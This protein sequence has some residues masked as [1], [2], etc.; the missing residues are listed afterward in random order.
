MD[1]NIFFI[2]DN[3]IRVFRYLC[4]YTQ[5]VWDYSDS[6]PDGDSDNNGVDFDNRKQVK[7]KHTIY[8]AE[9]SNIPNNTPDSFEHDFVGKHANLDIVSVEPLDVSDIEWMDGIKI[10]SNVTD[11]LAYIKEIYN[12]GKEAYE[13]SLVTTTDDYMTD[14]DYRLCLLEMGL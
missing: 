3:T 9:I 10:D 14:L 7:I 4:K 5:K 8:L 1:F 11:T 12:M 6:D 2:E 13:Q